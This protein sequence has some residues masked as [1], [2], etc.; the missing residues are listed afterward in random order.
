M[1]TSFKK[2][3]PRA[4]AALFLAIMLVLM[5]LTGLNKPLSY[6]EPHNLQYGYQFLTE[7]PV[8]FERV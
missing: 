7:G 6:D 5:V 1:L 8:L 2:L 3:D 4:W